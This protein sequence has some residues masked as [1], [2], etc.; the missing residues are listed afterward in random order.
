MSLSSNEKEVLI[1]VCIIL[2]FLIGFGLGFGAA[3][4]NLKTIGMSSGKVVTPNIK[5]ECIDNV[6][7]T[8]YIYKFQKE[9]Q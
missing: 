3:R 4:N 5:V 8:T 9:E 7:D 2:V 6:C 1:T